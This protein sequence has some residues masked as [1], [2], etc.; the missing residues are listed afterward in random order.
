LPLHKT[1][2]HDYLDNAVNAFKVCS[3]VVK[4][5]TQIHTHMCYSDFNAIIKQIAQ[6]DADA[7]TIETSRSDMALLEVFDSYQY[8]NEIGPGVYDIHSPNIPS[9][10]AILAVLEQASTKVPSANLWVNPDCDLKAR[11]WD[12]VTPTLKNMLEATK[13]ARA[14]FNPCVA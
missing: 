12:E 2:W 6:M 5:T 9:A 3:N 4:D 1:Q 11:N 13:I 8:P 10:E 7:I 14:R